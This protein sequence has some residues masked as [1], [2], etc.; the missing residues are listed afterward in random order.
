M[1]TM[2][3]AAPPKGRKKCPRC[4][5]VQHL[6]KFIKTRVSVHG[7]P[8]LLNYKLCEDCRGAERRNRSKVSPADYLF[9]RPV[10]LAENRYWPVGNDVMMASLKKEMSGETAYS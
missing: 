4:G 2:A 9:G 10:P 7:V 8:H 3:K 1:A 5:Q 6:K